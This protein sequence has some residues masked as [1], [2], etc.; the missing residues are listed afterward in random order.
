MELN[1]RRIF[2]FSTFYIS[3][4]LVSVISCNGI[5]SNHNNTDNKEKEIE[6]EAQEAFEK[7]RRAVYLGICFAAGIGQLR[8]SLSIYS[9]CE[10]YAFLL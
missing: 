6:Q 10:F 4:C 8:N 9:M 2:L 7:L 5:D 3:I 1:V